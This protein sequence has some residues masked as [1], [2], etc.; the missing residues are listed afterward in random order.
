MYKCKF[1]NAT[2][3]CVFKVNFTYEIK[4]IHYIHT[5]ILS[6]QIRMFYI[7]NMYSNENVNIKHI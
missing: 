5:Y 6:N 7:L 4:Y 3:I 1:L 2:G